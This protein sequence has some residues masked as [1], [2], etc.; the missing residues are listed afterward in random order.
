MTTS[1]GY[2]SSSDYGVHFGMGVAR[3]LDRVELLWPSGAKQVLEQVA[4][5]RVVTVTEPQ[6]K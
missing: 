4:A 3:T 1:V 5:N 2:A 6:G